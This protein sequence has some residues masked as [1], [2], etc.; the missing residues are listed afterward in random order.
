MFNKAETG[1]MR[2]RH[3][4]HKIN[5]SG[6]LHILTLCIV[7]GT[8]MELWLIRQEGKIKVLISLWAN[9]SKMLFRDNHWFIDTVHRTLIWGLGSPCFILDPVVLCCLILNTSL[10][11]SVLSTHLWAHMPADH[12]PVDQGT[13][14]QKC[15]CRFC[16]HNFYKPWPDLDKQ[17]LWITAAHELT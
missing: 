7:A 17:V 10:S 1:G 11:A 4:T 13:S 3:A 12:N 9:A 6:G 14:F 2:K 8:N 16:L 5:C 15:I